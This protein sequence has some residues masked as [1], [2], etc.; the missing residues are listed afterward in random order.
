MLPVDLLGKG[1]AGCESS[2]VRE[3]HAVGLVGPY[4]LNRQAK[5]LV[6][7]ILMVKGR[8]AVVLGE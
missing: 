2:R 8:H 5:G 1:K 3:R 4:T 6:W 7:C